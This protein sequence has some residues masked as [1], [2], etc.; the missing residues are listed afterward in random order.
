MSP[1][2]FEDLKNEFER[3]L[4]GQRCQASEDLAQRMQNLR[5]AHNEALD[6]M[7]REKVQA[8]K[9]LIQQQST[10]Q[11]EIEELRASN[12]RAIEELKTSNQIEI[13]HLQND[14]NESDSRVNSLEK[15]VNSLKV[16]YYNLSLTFVAN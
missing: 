3:T 7:L 2:A 8:E 14:K 4:E 10:S 16:V 9:K 13:E 6:S 12:L 1:S 15:T 5:Q 11:R